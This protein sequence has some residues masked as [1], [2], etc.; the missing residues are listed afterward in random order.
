MN[1]SLKR[2]VISPIGRT[3]PDDRGRPGSLVFIFPDPCNLSRRTE[4]IAAQAA[5]VQPLQKNKVEKFMT[6]FP[7]QGIPAGTGARRIQILDPSE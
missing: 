4:K 5:L 3:K 1:R 7:G 6:E 2:A